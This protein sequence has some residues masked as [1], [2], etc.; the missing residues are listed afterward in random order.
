MPGIFGSQLQVHLLLQPV[1]L[2]QGFSGLW[3]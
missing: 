2:G 3:H 1:L